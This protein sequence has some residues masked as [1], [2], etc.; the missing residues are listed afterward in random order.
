MTR[1]T[2]KR[3]RMALLYIRTA[4]E[5]LEE[6]DHAGPHPLED[7]MASLRDAE[8]TLDSV[9]RKPESEKSPERVEA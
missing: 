4:R 6:E 9:L 8:T 3:R 1:P 7:A 5:V 2:E